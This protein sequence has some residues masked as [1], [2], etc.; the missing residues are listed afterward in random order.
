MAEKLIVY[1][2]DHGYTDSYVYVSWLDDYYYTQD[3]DSHSFALVATQ[4]GS[5]YVEYTETVTDGYVREALEAGTT[6]ITGLDHLEGEIVKVTANGALVAT[7]TV[8]G[9]SVTIPGTAVVT[10]QAGLP[11][12]MKVRTM[13]MSI[14]QDGN[15]LQSR[16]KRI[17]ETVIRYI[18]SSLG[19]AGQEYDGTEY[20]TDLDTTFSTEAQDDTKPTLG[21]FTP[22]AYTVITSDDPLPFTV[23]ASIVTVE[24]EESR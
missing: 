21:G 20:L 16:I 2:P 11:Y 17:S 19:K 14:P 12:K 18:R 9:G 24:V 10:Y 4:L 3:E 5:D 13:R 23:L 15:T 1:I 8:S 7:G 6:T 22:D